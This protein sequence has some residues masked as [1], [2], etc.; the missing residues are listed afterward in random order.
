V[1][2]R[3][4]CL[5]PH[6]LCQAGRPL[7]GYRKLRPF[8]CAACRRLLPLLGGKHLLQLLHSTRLG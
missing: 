8:A 4:L 2:V 3:L 1:A 7:P 5:L 6:R